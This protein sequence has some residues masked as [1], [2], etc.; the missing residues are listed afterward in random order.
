[1]I[2]PEQSAAYYEA[3]GLA[4]GEQADPPDLEN[5]NDERHPCA[6][7]DRFLY[8]PPDDCPACA[9]SGFVDTPN[10]WCDRCGLTGNCPDCD[11]DRFRDERGNR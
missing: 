8:G 6:C 11:P 2:T 9:G 1:M 7:R 3:R 5:D 10:E 4:A